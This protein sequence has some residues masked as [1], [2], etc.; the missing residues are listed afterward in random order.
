MNETVLEIT[1]VC[2]SFG[3]IRALNGVDLQVPRGKIVSIIGPNG[4]GKTTLFN[5]ITGVLAA[6]R[7]SVMLRGRELLGLR[8]DQIYRA[9]VA[10]TFQSLELFPNMT[11]REHAM[12]GGQRLRARS[13]PVWRKS[14]GTKEE[15]AA[16]QARAVLER[17]KERL[18][19]DRHGDPARTLSYANRRRLEI[20]RGLAAEPD[21]LL[22][23]EPAAGMNP[24]ERAELTEI[25]GGLRDE[26]FTIVLIEHFME[27]VRRISDVVAVLNHGEKIAEGEPNA[28]LE[29][30]RVVKAYLGG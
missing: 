26:G 18:T 19:P 4:S 22:L 11:L 27:L 13:N 17:F 21:V 15:Y 16:E 30:P 7:G 14:R 2:K 3:G 6:D 23:D 28:V 25:I 29:D 24:R 10:R 8:P 5:V 12:I 20:S 9:G 1:N